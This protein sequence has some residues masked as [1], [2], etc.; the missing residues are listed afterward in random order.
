MRKILLL[1][2]CSFLFAFVPAHAYKYTLAA[3]MIFQNE[4]P[5]LREWIEYHKLLGVEHFYLINNCS[6]DN[7][8]EVLQP[9][10]EAGVVEVMECK[11]NRKQEMAWVCL[12]RSLYTEVISRVKEDVKWLL[13]VDADEY[14]V[15][16]I[17]DT[18]VEMLQRYDDPRTASL[19][20]QWV[21]FG[22]SCVDSLEENELLIEKLW[23]NKGFELFGKSIVR[24][25]RI[26][27]MKD[28]HKPH[29]KNCF[30]AI[31]VDRN[32]AQVN[33]YWMRDEK[34]AWAVKWPRRQRWGMTLSEFRHQMQTTNGQAYE[35]YLPITRF[36]SK[37]KESMGIVSNEEKR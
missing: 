17:E 20:T 12:Q 25:D 19:Y 28:P 29:F 18:I 31:K 36:L 11:E 32:I 23:M 10:M 14:Y 6:E 4:A 21:T 5:Y 34:Y 2:L 22:T 8:E 33:H 37:L 13:I 35:N 27:G 3:T 24:P 7:W 26:K 9:Y 15:P 1:S 30:Y 16:L